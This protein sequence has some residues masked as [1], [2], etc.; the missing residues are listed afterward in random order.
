L[1]RGGRPG[2]NPGPT[3]KSGWEKVVGGVYC[4]GWIAKQWFKIPSVPFEN[5]PKALRFWGASFGPVYS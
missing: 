4:D 2:E 5:A 3:V 1:C